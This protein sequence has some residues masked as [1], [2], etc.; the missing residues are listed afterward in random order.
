MNKNNQKSIIKNVMQ[1]LLKLCKFIPRS[2]YNCVGVS[3]LPLP[4]IHNR[5]F[6]IC[7]S[8]CLNV[9]RCYKVFI[10]PALLCALVA[11]L[12]FYFRYL[13]KPFKWKFCRLDYHRNSSNAC[14]SS[15][16]DRSTTFDLRSNGASRSACHA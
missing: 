8:G 7:K 15:P 13:L 4:N 9:K 16:E 14:N 5:I 10:F 3:K 12:P 6:N 11:F 1:L 2:P